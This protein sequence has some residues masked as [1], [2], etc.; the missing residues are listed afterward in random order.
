MATLPPH[1]IITHDKS[2]LRPT[3]YLY[4]VSIKCLVRNAA[5]EVLVV[6]ENNR[7]Y[8]DL[9]GGG[10]DH[11]EQ[12]KQ[13]I[14]RELYE[15][16]SLQGDFTYRVITVEEPNLLT[17]HNFWQMRLIFEVIPENITVKPGSDGDDVTFVGPRTLKDSTNP[18]EQLVYLYN[19]LALEQT[20]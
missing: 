12:I 11:G 14:A 6:K 3:D 13:V 1:G 18:N 2:S 4:R 7:D 5:G 8:W 20:K 16:V 15:E 17:T 19:A 9:P 10:M